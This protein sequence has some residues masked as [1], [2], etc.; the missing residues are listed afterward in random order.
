MIIKTIAFFLLIFAQLSFAQESYHVSDEELAQNKAY[1]H[2][3]CDYL[4]HHSSPKIQLIGYSTF[5]ADDEMDVQA[6]KKIL[7]KAINTSS[8]EQT[9]FLAD[10]LCHTEKNLENWCHKKQIHQVHQLVDPENIMTYINELHNEKNEKNENIATAWLD[11]V[12]NQGTYSNSF[13]FELSLILS[14]EIALFNEENPSF[15]F[16][17][18]KEETLSLVKEFRLIE[19]GLLEQSFV[20]NYHE[21]LSYMISMDIMMAQSVSMRKFSKFCKNNEFYEQCHY[22]A[23]VLKTDKTFMGQ[24]MADAI[25]QKINGITKPNTVGTKS[26]QMASCLSQSQDMLF[27]QSLNPDFAKQYLFDAIE[28]G[29]G[30]A[31]YNLAFKV[32]D[33]VRS[34][35]FN[36]DFNPHDCE[37][38]LK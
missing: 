1:Y 27:A 16:N 8:D 14:K 35:G 34:H 28:Y 3:L 32:Y 18:D 9:L 19:K 15:I 12:A 30:Q 23:E 29:E 37:K 20:E 36:P 11:L 38:K 33:T 24:M 22:I 31:T 10:N 4:R 21:S 2:A 26:Y 5:V 6:I 17:Q 25:S 13:L 7:D